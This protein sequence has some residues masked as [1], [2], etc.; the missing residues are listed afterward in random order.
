MTYATVQNMID[1]F[2]EREVIALSDRE[3]NG[4]VDTD[5]LNKALISADNE[6]NAYLVIKYSL[7]L[8]SVPSIVSDF[9]CDIARYRLSGASVVETDEVRIRYRD[10]IKFFEKVSH[11]TASLGVDSANQVPDHVGGVKSAASNRIFNA[12]T[13][14]DF[15]R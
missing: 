12:T 15:N 3:N 14:A 10:A 8:T 2:D 5:V 13:L 1:R 11:G 7:P 9:A 6:I 4:V